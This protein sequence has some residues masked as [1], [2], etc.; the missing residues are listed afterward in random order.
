ML[1]TKQVVFPR[2]KRKRLIVQGY[3]FFATHGTHTYTQN[4]KLLIFN[5]L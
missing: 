3:S 5:T 1:Y 4:Y 2:T